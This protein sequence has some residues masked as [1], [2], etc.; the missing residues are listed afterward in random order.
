MKVGI[1]SDT[2]NDPQHATPHVIQQFKKR[3]VKLVVHCGDIEA[4]D[5]DAG[6][7]GDFPVVCALNL[8]QVEKEK[9]CNCP[10]GW[11]FTVPDQRVVDVSGVRMYV[12]H[13]RS[14][15][16]LVESEKSIM[17]FLEA[18][19]KDHDGLRWFFAGHTHQQ[20]YVKTPMAGLVNPGA[21]CNSCNGHA[22]AIVDTDT[23]EVVFSRIPIGNPCEKTFSVGVISDTLKISQMDSN[24]WSHLATE[25]KTRDVTTIIHCGNIEASDIGRPEL[26][27]FAVRV[28]LRDDQ[29]HYEHKMP[30]NWRAIDR[31]ETVVEVNGFRFF[32]QL[33]LGASFLDQTEIEMHSLCLAITKDFPALDYVL[34]GSECNALYV[35]D[36]HTSIINPGD[37]YRG[38]SFAVICLPD[39]QEITFGYVPVDP[40]PPL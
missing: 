36:P 15:R 20:F 1:M 21:V 7:Y 27:D 39:R 30:C 23:N 24:F 29:L 19:R 17:A 28:Y 38:R 6:L 12:G 22:Y 8:E 11:Q 25:F 10:P 18:W 37:A 9:F 33:D 4:Q 31:H 2:H 26:A 34:C 40:L 14:W 16:F 32:V 3:G 35:E 5:L 13:K